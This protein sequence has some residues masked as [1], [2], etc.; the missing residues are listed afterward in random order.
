MKPTSCITA[1]AACVLAFGC[2][3][4][5]PSPDKLKKDLKSDIVAPDMTQRIVAPDM[6]QK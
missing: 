6:V 5:A 1:L 4:D 2:N 3:V